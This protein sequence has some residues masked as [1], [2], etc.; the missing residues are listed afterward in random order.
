MEYTVYDTIQQVVLLKAPTL[1]KAQYAICEWL[2]TKLKRSQN[3]E[4]THCED[5]I[6]NTC[7]I[8]SEIGKPVN[9]LIIRKD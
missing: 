9:R 2:V 3:L 4:I 1:D 5:S 8:V 6:D 7:H